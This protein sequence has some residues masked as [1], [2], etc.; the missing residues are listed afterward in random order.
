MKQIEKHTN[1][2]NPVIRLFLVLLLVGGVAASGWGQ[3]TLIY[4]TGFEAAEGFTA[5]TSYNNTTIKYDGP[6]GAQWGTYYGTAST[7]NQISGSQS[8]QMRWYTSAPE[9]LGYTFT[10]FDLASVTK[11]LFKAKRAAQVI[12]VT[13]SYSIDG[14][15]NFINEEVFALT[16]TATE[17]TYDISETGEF[18]NV[19]VRFQIS[20]E[21][22]PTNTAHLIIDDVAVYGIVS[23]P[24]LFVST[25][26][27]SNLDYTENEGPS[28]PQSF[29]L[30]GANLDETDVTV[31]APASFEVSRTE[32]GGYGS[33]ITLTE[34]NGAAEIIWVRLQAGETPGVY[35]GNVAIT[36]GGT[37][38]PTHVAV[39]GRVIP[40]GYYVDFEGDGETKGSYVSNT[41]TLSGIDWNMTE[42]LIGTIEGD[43]KNGNRSARLRGYGVSSITML[44]D[45]V[46]GAGNVSF[47][48]RRYG[49]D[50]QVDWKVEYSVNQGGEWKQLGNGFTAPAT[51]EVQTFNEALNVP[52]DVRIRIKRATEDGSTT[53]NRLNIDDILITDFN[54]PVATIFSGT[55]DWSESLRWSDGIPGQGTNV[56][57]Q[58]EVTVD[59]ASMINNLTIESGAT[60]LDN[61][62][63][64]INGDFIMEREID[65]GEFKWHFLS[66]PVTGMTIIGSD[67]VPDPIGGALPG[68][69]DF[70]AFDES[71]ELPWINIRGAGGAPNENFDAVFVPGKG[72]LVAYAAD[73]GTST[74]QFAGTMQTGNIDYPLAY[75]PGKDWS[76]WN[77]LG[78]PYPSAIQWH[79]DYATQFQ[80]NAVAIYH[81]NKEGGAGYVNIEQGGFIPANQGFFAHVKSE[82]GGSNFTFT[83][84]MRSHGGDFMKNDAPA[85]DQLKLRLASN[86]YWDETTIRIREGSEFSRDRQDAVKLFSLNAEFPQLFTSSSDH[87]QVSIN[88]IPH[89]NEEQSI[90]LGMRIPEDG[91]YS[92]SLQEMSGPFASSIL[93]LEDTHAGVIRDLHTNPVYTFEATEGV[94]SGRFLIHFGKQDDDT[95]D[96]PDADAPK[97]RIWHHD[98]TL[99]VDNPEGEIALHLYDISGRRLQS[100][101]VAAGQ[102]RFELNLPAGVY[103][104]KSS[105][106]NQH[107]TVKII[108]Q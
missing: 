108:I 93:L 31:T 17:F 80:Q 105:G 51:D 50:A 83:N 61:E 103:V 77:L 47:S 35:S 75:T 65:D 79:N 88:S 4:S 76:G 82:Q 63:L 21:T 74:F 95:T 68:N 53:D 44:A 16:T 102:H 5:A 81:P 6:E 45:K 22:A 49:T 19:R 7:N 90:T 92:L 43:W 69:F 99:H 41:V 46:G 48:Y 15:F 55:G 73:Y 57:I 89:I 30:T 28:T 23:E 24:T 84:A 18:A 97:A 40:A 36:R 72:Y 78:N 58:G 59:V 52:W 101:N 33:T 96:I 9:N 106:K 27:I 56:T 60:L 70:F 100:H 91:E 66:A 29:E 12:S 104:V 107:E 1:R 38:E 25:A 11:V 2:N 34:Y 8:M 64:N 98:N 42:A 85:A 94:V 37:T 14:G 54:E 10:D 3:E 87:V 13:A 32:V 39:S 71:A 86:D 67:F 62:S 20:F 26:S